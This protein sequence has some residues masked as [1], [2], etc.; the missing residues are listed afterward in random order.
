MWHG[1]FGVENLNLKT[2]QRAELIV[3][4]RALGPAD[5]L[6]PAH[7]NHWRTRLDGDAAIFE[8]LFDEDHITVGAFKGWLGTI[9][10][11]SPTTI[12]H[13]LVTVTLDTRASAVVTFSRGGTDYL[14][15]V[16]FGY[17]GGGEWP[18]WNESRIECG[19]YL[20]NNIQ[21]W[22]SAV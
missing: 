14:R 15:V 6:Q 11:V 13:S 20:L 7:L 12:D 16:F 8:A 17:A 19:Q 4:L 9:F 3:A 1:Y 10:S 21:D 5:D 18:T 22:E 2:A